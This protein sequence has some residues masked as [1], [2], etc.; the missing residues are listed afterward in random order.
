MLL[1]RQC[2]TEW[3]R[4]EVDLWARK[5]A[6]AADNCSVE[7]EDKLRAG[8]ADRQRL[9][10]VGKQQRGSQDNRLVVA[11]ADIGCNVVAGADN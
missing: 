5:R 7:F 10:F 1:A 4:V 8:F 2:R 3:K 11:G 9:D 6:G